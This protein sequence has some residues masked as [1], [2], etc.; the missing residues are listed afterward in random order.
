[1]FGKLTYCF[2]FAC[3]DNDGINITRQH[4]GRIGNGFATPQLHLCTSQHDGVTTKLTHGHVKRDP[5]AGR[6]LVKNH[7]QGLSMKRSVLI[8]RSF[9]Q[10]SPR[11]LAPMGC[12]KH[13][14]QRMGRCFVQINKMT[15]HNMFTPPY[16]WG[17]PFGG[18]LGRA[19]ARAITPSIT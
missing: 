5:G 11:F 10:A 9:G 7:G 17:V 12:L 18:W 8:H 13:P 6:W 2:M 4:P 14:L 19:Y 16:S 3:P 1:M 15:G